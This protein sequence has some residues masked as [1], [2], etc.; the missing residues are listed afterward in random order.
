M[1]KVLRFQTIEE[2]LEAADT[3]RSHDSQA[4]SLPTGIGLRVDDSGRMFFS[5][6]GAEGFEMTDELQLSFDEL[7]DAALMRCGLN[8]VDREG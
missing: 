5:G 7:C 2:I 4:P 6:D 3:V 1:I 8:H